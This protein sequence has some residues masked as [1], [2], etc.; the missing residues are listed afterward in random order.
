LRAGLAGRRVSVK[1]ALLAGDVVVGVGNI[2][3]SEALF[4]AGIDPRTPANRV[5]PVRCARL[6]EAVRQVL[7]RAL[8]AGGST[9]RDFHDAQGRAGAFQEQ[10]A[11]YGR[12]GQSCRR[13][14]AKVQRIQQGQRSTY[15]CPSCQHR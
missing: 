11:V 1:Q 9:L 10:A 13:C 12:E 4:V 6:V 2:Y 15:F 14:G 3:C 8:E 5:G 7:G